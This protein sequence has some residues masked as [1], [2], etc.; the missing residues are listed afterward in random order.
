MERFREAPLPLR[1]SVPEVSHDV[2]L[3]A[4]PKVQDERL[5][6]QLRMIQQAPERGLTEQTLADVGMTIEMRPQSAL[7]IIRVN[8][9][10]ALE[11]Q[12]RI[13][14]SDEIL[15]AAHQ[16]VT[17]GVAMT[18]IETVADLELESGLRL[19]PDFS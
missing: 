17:G 8:H 4:R 14:P 12:H 10:H 3:S 13:R 16:I 15:E 9:R 11:P 5:G 7:R 19:A 6:L 18:G 2:R 1:T